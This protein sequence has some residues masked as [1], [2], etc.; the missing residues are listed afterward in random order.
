MSVS[1]AVAQILRHQP[2]T[3]R[4]ISPINS[5]VDEN[6][7]LSTT[8]IGAANRHGREAVVRMA[9]AGVLVIVG[10]RLLG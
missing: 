6:D 9:L 5:V 4:E 10:V 7:F 1:A 8:E 3:D 2:Y